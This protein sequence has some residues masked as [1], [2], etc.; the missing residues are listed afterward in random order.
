MLYN[1][2]IPYI[3]CTILDKEIV[4]D[5]TNAPILEDLQCILHTFHVFFTRKRPFFKDVHTHSSEQKI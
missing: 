1:K 5:I 2:F 4:I 3:L